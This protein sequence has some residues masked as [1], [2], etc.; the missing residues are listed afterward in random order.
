[1]AM[2]RPTKQFFGKYKT[3]KTEKF[4]TSLKVGDPVMVLTGGNPKRGRDLKGKVGKIKA[5][6]PKSNRVL[7]DGLNF[8]VRHQRARSMN[9]PAG[10]I[11]K[12]GSVDISNVMYYVEAIKRPVRLASTTLES[13]KKARAYR[14]PETK[15]L[16]AIDEGGRA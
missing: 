7:I 13:G 8:V 12:E 10:K 11:R 14:D 2:N 15:K 4:V 5:F 3:K 9:E 6:L 16:I 1:M